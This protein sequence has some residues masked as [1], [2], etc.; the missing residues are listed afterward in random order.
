MVV[1]DTVVVE[2]PPHDRSAVAEPITIPTARI[3]RIAA[4]L[5]SGGK[6]A[7]L[8]DCHRRRSC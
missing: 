8:S 3:L 1:T 5:P 2:P 7:R 6:T 4:S